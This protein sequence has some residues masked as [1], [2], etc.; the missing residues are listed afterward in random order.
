MTDI[1]RVIALWGMLL[2]TFVIRPFVQPAIARLLGP[3]G[4]W[5]GRMRVS[6]APAPEAAEGGQ[7]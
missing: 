4:W 5:P 3:W 1:Y 2:D 7:P 6:P